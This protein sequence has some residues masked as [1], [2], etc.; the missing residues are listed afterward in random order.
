VKCA[1]HVESPEQAVDGAQQLVETH[2]A[3]AVLPYSMP[4][5]VVLRSVGGSFSM[6]TTCRHDIDAASTPVNPKSATIPPR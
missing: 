2:D 6:P 1:P 5:A 4:H 3:H